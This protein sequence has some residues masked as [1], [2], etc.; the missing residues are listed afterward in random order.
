[1]ARVLAPGGRLAVLASRRR[2][3]T[4]VRALEAG[5]GAG[6]GVHM[7]GADELTGALSAR[8]FDRVTRRDSGLVQYVGG[9]RM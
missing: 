9:R 6:L 4:P 5:L 8:G 7:F 1:M 2:G 3:P